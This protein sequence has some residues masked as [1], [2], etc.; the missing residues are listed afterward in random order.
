MLESDHRRITAVL[1]QIDRERPGLDRTGRRLLLDRLIAAESRH[2]AGEEMA[3]WPAVGRLD[4]GAELVAEGRRQEGDA[5]YVIDAL[6]FS[7]PGPELDDHL[8]AAAALIRR[9]IDFEE[10]EVW[11]LV[12]RAGGPL[13]ARLLG[14]RYRMART[15]APTRPHPHGPE[16]VLGLAT[17]GAAAAAADRLRDRMGGRARRLA[18][19]LG[20]PGHGTD[21]G[22]DLL[23]ADHRGLEEMMHRLEAAEWPDPGDVADLVRGVSMHDAIER[24]H[25]YPLVRHRVASGND[26]YDHSLAEHGRISAALSEV[27]R[28]PP[29]DRHRRDEVERA[30]TLIR[31]H[32]AEEEG[33]VFPAL[34]ARLSPQELAELGSRLETARRRAPTRPH[35]H[36]AGAGLG[37]RLSRMVAGPLDR[38]RDTVTRR[39]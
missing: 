30:V 6:R 11:P 4:G 28:R 39:R 31:T 14:W 26:V 35:P 1:D 24:E 36:V 23:A 5:R 25:L 38:A 10:Q 2:E 17:V 37:A 19:P 32:V 16:G 29:G 22:L 18:G 3:F 12:R 7:Q 21:D 27:D 33:S 20:P 15:V 34:R 9:H 13:E 8:G